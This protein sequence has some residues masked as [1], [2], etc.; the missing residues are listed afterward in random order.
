MIT[1]YFLIHLAE[2]RTGH[3]Y[4]ENFRSGH[5]TLVQ[6]YTL[7]TALYMKYNMFINYTLRYESKLKYPP[8]QYVKMKFFL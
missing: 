1:N 5:V 3:K 7:Y 8:S 6:H 2:Q 4:C